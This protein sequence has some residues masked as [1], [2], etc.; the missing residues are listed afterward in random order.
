MYINKKKITLLLVLL[1]FS[2]GLFLVSAEKAEAAFGLDETIKQVKTPGSSAVYYLD[3][4]RGIKKAYVNAEAYLSYGNEW[5][6]VKVIKQEELNQWPETRLVK[7][8]GDARVYY[9][10]NGKKYWIQGEQ[11]FID[12]D[13]VW[14]RIVTINKIDL[15]QYR[16]VDNV[17]DLNIVM[18]GGGSDLEVG[19]NLALSSPESSFIP[20]G[21]KDN[22]VA[23]FSFESKQGLIK[24][25]SLTLKLDGVFNTDI[26]KKIYLKD[27]ADQSYEVRG[28]VNNRRAYFNL[29]TRPLVLAAGA[30]KDINIFVDLESQNEVV[31]ST[32]GVSLEDSSQIDTEA[33][34]SGDFPIQSHGMKLVDGADYLG[35]LTASEESIALVG[36]EAIIGNA[37]Q[38]LAKYRISETTKNEGVLIKELVFENIG[39]AKNFEINSFKLK[40]NSNKIIAQ[41]SEMHDNEIKFQL[42]DHGIKKG[43]YGYFTVYADIVGGEGKTIS[44]NL[45][46]VRARGR[47]HNFGLFTDINNLA[48]ELIIKGEIL[49]VIAR[50]LKSNNKVFKEQAGAIIGL[51]EIRND[52]QP[53][54]LEDMEISLVRNAS[55][56][57][58]DNILY[59]INYDSGE[60]I[61]YIAGSGLDSGSQT[62]GL[63]NTEIKAKDELVLALVIEMPDEADQGDSYK[64]ILNRI[65]YRAANGE[66]YSDEVNVVG[67]SLAISQSSLYIYRNNE[68]GEAVFIKGEEKAKIASFIMESSA[69]K[70]IRI[71]SLTLARASNFS[72]LKE[73]K[74]SFTPIL[75]KT[76]ECPKLS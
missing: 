43:G 26:I 3:H 49:G 23:V 61:N 8:P 13:F 22:L 10:D 52:I 15:E 12:F 2:A 16:L 17:N 74:L 11:E 33:R 59:I 35:R 50:D 42:D 71:S 37:D 41:A 20:L 7:T 31:N 57:G 54:V 51:F 29:A 34:V 68:I 53:I 66:Y 38:I 30:K 62:I 36:Q 65:V 39:T 75:T 70:D 21:A 56:P 47:E 5:S 55:A 28:T 18:A 24:I 73:W 72:S 19:V 14:D 45:K 32:F 76:W 44:L 63:G 58:L 60:V 46:E 27:A 69:G 25:N 9:I 64:I 1:V 6:D 40:N 4:N 67:R 48:E